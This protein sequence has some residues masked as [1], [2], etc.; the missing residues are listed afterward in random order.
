MSRGRQARLRRAR[1]V[2][3]ACRKADGT[4][5][6]AWRREHRETPDE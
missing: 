2:V 6:R 5:M 3:D 1:L 4:T